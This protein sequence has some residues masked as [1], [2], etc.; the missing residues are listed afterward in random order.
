MR[1][2]TPARRTAATESPPP[3]D[4][5][6]RAGRDRLGDGEGAAGE[7]LD[8]E[9]AHRSVPQHGPGRT[10][11]VAVA[12]DGLGADVDAEPVPDGGIVDAESGMRGIG[13][14]AVG[15]DVVDG[16]LE[17]NPMGTRGPLDVA[18]GV[19]EGL[20]HQRSAHRMP[21]GLQEGVGHG[22][23]DE[24]GVEAG[25]QVADDL[26]LARDLGAAE[27]ADER[28]RR[29]LEERAE[30]LE[31]ARHQQPGRRIGHV[32]HHAD[33][34]G[35]GAVRGPEGVVDVGVAR[36]REGGRERGV[37]GLLAGVEPQVLEQHHA[38]G[39]GL[40]QGRGHR[41]ADGVGSEDHAAVE[42][43]G[44]ALGDRPQGEGGIRGAPG[45]AQMRPDEERRPPVEGELQGRDGGANAGVVAD[46]AAAQRDV[47]VDPHEEPPAVELEVA[48]G[49]LGHD[50]DSGVGPGGWG[51][52]PLPPP[53]RPAAALEL[54]DARPPGGA[55]AYSPLS[56]RNLTRSTHR[57]E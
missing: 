30:M 55:R 56:A 9:H 35:V 26:Q 53:A 1:R 51:S 28:P 20:L 34:R 10:H 38:A 12:A 21:V 44:Q 13:V 52:E 42:K 14:D 39:A 41:L 19:D 18:G 46:D 50:R 32:A 6:R 4:R 7:R 23:A 40:R 22:P 48:D 27:D 36:G 33:R 3:H 5:G 49:S 16:Q 24:Q 47:E 54:A 15:D 45:A 11:G 29:R 37:V 25:Q 8:L 31:L 43:L 57:D 2:A 17:P